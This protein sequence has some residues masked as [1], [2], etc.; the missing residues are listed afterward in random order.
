MVTKEEKELM[1][2]QDTLTETI[3]SC[4]F[5]LNMNGIKPDTCI[6][7]ILDT[8]NFTLQKSKEIDQREYN[9]RISE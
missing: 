7:M 3:A 4:Y 9:K 1:K 5:Y 6:D 8:V 2:V